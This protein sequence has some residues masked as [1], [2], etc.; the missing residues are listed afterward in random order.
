[1]EEKRYTCLFGKNKTKPGGGL[2]SELNK[3]E[4]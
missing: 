1:M 2:G 4:K 3:K